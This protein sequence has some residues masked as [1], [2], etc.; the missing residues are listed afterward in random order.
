MKGFS[1]QSD[2]FDRQAQRYVIP[3]YLADEMGN[4][5]YSS[6]GTL[7]EYGLN[8]Y[9]V[10]AAHAI[11]GRSKVEDVAF[12]GIDGELHKVTDDAYSYRIYEA[13]D[14]VIVDF[15]RSKFDGKNYFDLNKEFSLIG[16]EKNAFSWTGFPQSWVKTKT[17]HRT[18]KTTSVLNDNV[19]ETEGGYYFKNA[20][21]FSITSK[22][23]TFNNLE[24]TGSYDRKKLDLKYKGAVDEGPS[25]KGMSGG[26]MYFFA[27]D[28]KFNGTLE[29]TFNFAGIGIEYVKDNR[30]KGVSRHKVIALL[31]DFNVNQAE[32]VK[33]DV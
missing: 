23:K 7:V 20:R 26:A 31:N 27:K 5:H 30:I 15:K 3:L 4:F 14:I 22:V 25:P 1:Y 17:I 28:Q 10:F 29:K 11:E 16:F 9:L 6:T 19:V 8:F 13:E 24:I 32:S 12:L 33:F 18:K 2:D 21:Y